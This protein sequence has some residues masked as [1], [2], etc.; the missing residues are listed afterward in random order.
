MK[1]IFKLSVLLLIALMSVGCASTEKNS[2]INYPGLAESSKSIEE[3]QTE[4]EDITGPIEWK[5]KE[6]LKYT[7]E[8][9]GEI[10][11]DFGLYYNRLIQDASRIVITDPIMKTENIKS[12]NTIPESYYNIKGLKYNKFETL[13]Q[14][15]VFFTYESSAY[16]TQYLWLLTDKK[17]LKDVSKNAKFSKEKGAFL[18]ETMCITNNNE[19]TIYNT[20]LKQDTCLLKI[21][22][23][24]TQFNVVIEYSLQLLGTTNQEKA[25]VAAKIAEFNKQRSLWAEPYVNE[26]LIVNRYGANHKPESLN[27][28]NSTDTDLILVPSVTYKMGTSPDER[29]ILYHY[30]MTHSDS[31]EESGDIFCE[32]NY[33]H[34]VELTSFYIGKTEITQAE[35]KKIMGENPSTYSGEKRPIENISWF[36]AIVFCNKLSILEGKIPCYS[37]YDETN[38]DKWIYKPHNEQSINSGLKCDFRADGYRLPTEAE[39]ECAAK[40]GGLE[41]FKY[42]GSKNTEDVGWTFASNPEKKETH[43][44]ARRKPNSLGIFDMTG[45]VYEWCWDTY[46]TYSTLPT[47]NP[48]TSGGKIYNKSRHVIRGGSHSSKSEFCTVTRREYLDANAR[49]PSVGFRIVCTAY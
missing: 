11:Y 15:D 47:F 49:S 29:D 20:I 18:G 22:V 6:A 9:K 36:D 3:F 41:S 21:R 34:Q 4:I 48:T 1:K 12:I 13:Q 39:W 40:A 32:D 28:I 17:V 24:F 35:Y 5:F 10:F 45:N 31:R 42:S 46:A 30:K 2:E 7:N 43:D 19:E 16:D 23:G 26:S 44:V 38:P 27:K 8:F 37:V 14:G 33:Q 25:Y